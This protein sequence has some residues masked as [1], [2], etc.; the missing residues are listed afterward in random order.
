MDNP[1]DPRT[2]T[3]E[4][5]SMEFG[6]LGGTNSFI[7]GVAHF[8]YFYPFLKSQTLGTFVVS[9]GITYGIGT[10]L[11][12]GTGGELPLYERF[13]PGGVGG[14]GD[15]R[16][17]QLYSLGPQVTLFSQNGTPQSVQ[18]IGGSKELLLSNEITFPIL[19]GLGIR[20]VIFSDAGQS[21]LLKDDI[22]HRINL[23]ASSGIRRALEI[24]VRAAGGG[25]RFPDQP[26]AG[27]PAYRVRGRRRLA[28]VAS[29]RV[30]AETDAK[31]W[32]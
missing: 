25:Y 17:Y 14:P 18:N 4:S 30:S 5:L 11:E 16:G 20:G 22:H 6:G 9:Q 7:K 8:R 28:A 3:V 13:F 15:V 2:G 10:N 23:Q 29:S 24:A 31:N 1:T 19:S 32:I 26:A 12:S 21:F 27:R